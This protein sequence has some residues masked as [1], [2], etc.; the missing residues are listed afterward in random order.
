MGIFPRGS[1]EM[2]PGFLDSSTVFP[3]YD[4]FRPRQHDEEKY[5]SRSRANADG[6]TCPLQQHLHRAESGPD[7]DTAASGSR[8]LSI[9]PRGM[10][11]SP[12]RNSGFGARSAGGF[13]VA[14]GIAKAGTGSSNYPPFAELTS[15]VFFLV[16]TD[17]GRW[18]VSADVYLLV[19]T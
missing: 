12:W 7:T 18:G 4:L 19:V 5:S 13:R 3:N 14:H 16:L 8:G 17:L 10:A 1:L 11:Q 9:P 6:G 2:L 15:G